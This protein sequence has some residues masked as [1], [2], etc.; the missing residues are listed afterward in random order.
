MRN[1]EQLQDLSVVIA[2]L[3]GDSL[4]GTLR[5]LNCGSIR[6]SEILVCIPEEEAKRLE[7][8]LPDNVEIVATAV[9]GQVA[10][11]AV[12][13]GLAKSNYVMQM[14]DDIYLADDSLEQLLSTLKKLGPGHV[15]AP[16]YK[17]PITNSYITQYHSGIRGLLASLEATL[18]CSAPWGTRR[19]GRL[20]RLG[21]GYWVD[22]RYIQGD[23]LEEDWL[24]GGCVM[25]T[26][27]DLITDCYYPLAGKAYTE[28]VVHSIKW[29]ERGCTL[30]TVVTAD[31]YTEVAPLV[32]NTREICSNF[33]ARV[34]VANLLIGNRFR[35]AVWYAV[36]LVR[37][38]ILALRMKI[39]QGLS[40]WR[41]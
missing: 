32:L 14:D 34:Y 7:I 9:R 8:D 25:C 21:I 29:R 3:G 39:K 30:W 13:L 28:D 4:A 12:G 17:N 2:T 36:Y 10:Q 5:G 33:K 38:L 24:P 1:G 19:G 18:L 31:C 11:R 40:A 41:K 23:T 35:L 22:P 20:T 6:P 15:V 27:E 16:L 26:R 37:R